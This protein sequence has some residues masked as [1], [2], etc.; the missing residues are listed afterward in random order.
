VSPDGT[1]LYAAY[2]DISGENSLAVITTSNNI[3]TQKIALGTGASFAGPFV[4]LSGDGSRAYV[5]LTNA[6]Q[7]AIAKVRNRNTRLTGVSPWWPLTR[8]ERRTRYYVA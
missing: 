7:L 1:K 6:S 3:V 2:T 5:T 4:A 8:S